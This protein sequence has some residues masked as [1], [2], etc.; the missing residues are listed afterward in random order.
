MS[1]RRPILASLMVFTVALM[2][3]LVLAAEDSPKG[4]GATRPA[5]DAPRIGAV[6]KALLYLY[7]LPRTSARA[8]GRDAVRNADA[9]STRARD[10]GP[11][12][13]GDQSSARGKSSVRDQPSV[14]DKG[15]APEPAPAGASGES[16][17]LGLQHLDA[18]RH[19]VSSVP[20]GDDIRGAVPAGNDPQRA[21]ADDPDGS[22]PI[23]SM[24]SYL[25]SPYYYERRGS[26][27]PEHKQEWTDYRYFDGQPGRYGYGR[28]TGEVPD[29]SIAGGYFRFG[30][31]EGYDR[32]R[33]DAVGTERT[34]RLL[35]RANTHLSR[36]LQ[37]FYEGRYRE[38][39]DAFKLAAETNQ[40]DPAARIYAAHALFGTGQYKEAVEIL[41]RA[42]E[43]EPDLIYL[44]YDMREDYGKRADFDRHLEGLEKA[45]QAFPR[46]L[47]RLILL[48]YVRCY[49][50]QRD[51]AYEPLVKARKL[52]QRDELVARLL[53][54]S[55]P[56][57]VVI[58]ELNANKKP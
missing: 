56:P 16:N 43:L 10:K 46:N 4:D 32:G 58:D 27:L 47:D 18:I 41:R 48:G 1:F 49:S 55:Q 7:Q 50:H 19:S 8:F 35:A 51:K 20:I 14:R 33:M 26:R 6:Q 23:Q 24:S 53:K 39:A 34:Q 5:A 37:F 11:S 12:P 52:D 25:V 44:N 45:Q 54:A 15:P 29:D 13:V 9:S 40:G 2:A 3:R 30:F 38:A 17:R 28:Y 31:N 42:F 57:D 21:Q 22:E 36:G